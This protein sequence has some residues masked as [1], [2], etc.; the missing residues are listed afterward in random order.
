[1][2]SIVTTISSVKY[3]GSS[4]ICIGEEGNPSWRRCAAASTKAEL[5]Y[6]VAKQDYARSI[7]ND[8]GGG[9]G[10]KN[11]QFCVGLDCGRRNE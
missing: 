8:H 7:P 2:T 9:G 6:G 5:C 10:L 4:S 1:M 3:I 11:L